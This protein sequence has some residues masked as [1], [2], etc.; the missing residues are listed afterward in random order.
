MGDGGRVECTNT[1]HSV[2]TEF[3]TSSS[4]SLSLTKCWK[5]RGGRRWNWGLAWRELG[6]QRRCGKVQYCWYRTWYVQYSTDEN[7]RVE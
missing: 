1:C 6:A 2:P 3:G 4:D 7:V 5:S